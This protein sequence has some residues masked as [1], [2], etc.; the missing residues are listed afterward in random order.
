MSID[1]TKEITQHV[2]YGAVDS[3]ATWKAPRHDGIPFELLQQLWHALGGISIKWS[4]NGSKKGHPMKESPKRVLSIIPKERDGKKVNNWRPNTLFIVIYKAFPKHYRGGCNRCW[5]ML[6]AQSKW[7]FYHYVL[8]WTILSWFKKPCIGPTLPIN[9]RFSW[10]WTFPMHMI[11][12]HDV[13]FSMLWGKWT[14][15]NTFC[16]GQT[17][18]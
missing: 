12:S 8:S 15:M 4:I 6:L 10:N 17:P 1:L 2:L 11:R 5:V 7:H 14:F 3:M 9:L 18:I 16:V 13:F